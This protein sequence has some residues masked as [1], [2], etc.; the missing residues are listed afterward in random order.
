MYGIDTALDP[1]LFKESMESGIP[2][3]LL[4]LFKIYSTVSQLS[5]LYLTSVQ[6]S[7]MILSDFYPVI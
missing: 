3:C 4:I 5:G 1:L 2:T 7:N 6:L